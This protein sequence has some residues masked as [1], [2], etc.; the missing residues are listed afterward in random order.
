MLTI[1]LYI[2]LIHVKNGHWYLQKRKKKKKKKKKSNLVSNF[3]P[4]FDMSYLNVY[5]HQ[6]FKK[7]F[8]LQFVLGWGKLSLVWL[9]YKRDKC[10]DKFW[11]HRYA[12]RLVIV[13][14]VFAWYMSYIFLFCVL[15]FVAPSGKEL[16]SKENIKL[17]STISKTK[18]LFELVRD[19]PM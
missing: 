4:T 15:A 8:V 17:L 19:I 3:Y 16:L 11:C 2:Q 14:V 6:K 9:D 10:C 13:C 1:R 7:S 12:R 5:P 18:G